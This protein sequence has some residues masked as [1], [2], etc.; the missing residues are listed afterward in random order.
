MLLLDR[1]QEFI[2]LH[3]QLDY[4]DEDATLDEQAEKILY[5]YS[6][7]L[8]SLDVKEQLSIATLAEALIAL[9]TKFSREPIQTVV[10]QKKFWTFMECEPNIWIIVGFLNNSEAVQAAK[11]NS[12][13]LTSD[14]IISSDAL[15][16]FLQ[17][18]YHLYYTMN[19]SIQSFLNV[20]PN[21]REGMKIIDDIML[22]QRKIRKL[23]KRIFI[24]EGDIRKR[25]EDSEAFVPEATETMEELMKELASVQNHLQDQLIHPHYT[26]GILKMKLSNFIQWYVFQENLNHSSVFSSLNSSPL[27][28]SFEFPSDN[29]S[30]KLNFT[31]TSLLRLVKSI[32]QSSPLTGLS[33]NMIFS[34]DN[35]VL[36]SDCNEF[37]T[38]YLMEFFYRCD[39]TIKLGSINRKLRIAMEEF[40]KSL[41]FQESKCDYNCF[42]PQTKEKMF[43]ALKVS[44]CSVVNDSYHSS[45]LLVALRKKK[46]DFRLVME[47]L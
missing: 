39:Q 36:W 34:Y 40:T 25:E 13:H 38:N 29:Q 31:L 33:I 8:S 27:K 7:T 24:K 37:L 46:K 32:T 19:G 26:L 41:F 22:T 3:R 4:D 42:D 12:N 2:I 47:S 11:T 15:K 45:F 6:T 21:G 44:R 14:Q 28:N 16:Y 23:R 18:F 35:K 30:R 1:L 17:R 9:T 5:F 10:M 43:Q 20:T